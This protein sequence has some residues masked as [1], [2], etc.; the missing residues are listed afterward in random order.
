VHTL[1]FL[2]EGRKEPVIRLQRHPLIDPIF[3]LHPHLPYFQRKWGK[4]GWIVLSASLAGRNL[5][6]VILIAQDPAARSPYIKL[7]RHLSFTIAAILPA[8][9]GKV[10][11]RFSVP[12]H[13]DHI[14]RTASYWAGD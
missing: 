14:K 5:H 9:V 13:D 2:L 10:K 8:Q 6:L 11:A 4:L 3:G 7:L 12:W 1:T